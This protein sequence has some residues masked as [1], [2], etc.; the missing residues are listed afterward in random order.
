MLGFYLKK[1]AAFFL[2]PFSLVIIFISMG[3][4]LTKKKHPYKNHV[5]ILAL[6]LLCLFSTPWAPDFLLR[7]LEQRF[8]PYVLDK[9]KP[10]E[11]IMVLGGGADFR[12]DRP[13]H[14]LLSDES[15]FRVLE[16]VRIANLWPDA[17]VIFSGAKFSNAVTTA[18][19]MASVAISLGV[20]KKNVVLIKESMDTHDEAVMSKK[21]LSGKTFALVTSAPHMLRSVKL[22]KAQGLTPIPA[23][24]Y[25]HLKRDKN[26]WMYFLPSINNVG[27]VDVAFHEYL[28]LAWSFLRGQID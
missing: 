12:E 11:S 16:A 1:S 21:Y 25:Y 2:K 10:I 5:L 27:K 15:L 4:F 20:S 14:M 19:I 3:I 7:T 9:E 17:K 23:P 18:Q 26:S 28:G 13:L 8:S 6:F 24:G 22:F